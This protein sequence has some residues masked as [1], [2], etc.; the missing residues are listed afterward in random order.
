MDT[1]QLEET[2]MVDAAMMDPMDDLFGEAVNDLGVGVGVGLPPIPLPP[3][4]MLR[5]AELQHRGCCT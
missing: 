5:I 1:S 4:L 3:G 2:S